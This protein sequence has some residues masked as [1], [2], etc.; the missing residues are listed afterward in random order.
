[1]VDGR[2]QPRVSSRD[3]TSWVKSDL[4]LGGPGKGARY[5]VPQRDMFPETTQRALHHPDLP[6]AELSKPRLRGNGA[7]ADKG[8]VCPCSW[9]FFPL[10][11][12]LRTY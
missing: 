7:F 5:P 10:R 9:L 1:M 2:G 3:Q 6:T 8:A 12:F 4:F 11:C